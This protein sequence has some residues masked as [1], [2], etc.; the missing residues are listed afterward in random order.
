MTAGR[1]HKFIAAISACFVIA[2]VAE[3]PAHADTWILKDGKN[4]QDIG[5][6]P[7]GKYIIEISQFK[8]LIAQGKSS[9]AKKKL[10]EI[11]T[12]FPE[13]A[14][15]DL[16]AYM[17]AESFYARSDWARA[18]KEYEKFLNNYP[19]S[20]LYQA[21]LERRYDIATGFIHGQ[22][23]KVFKI[24]RFPAYSQG[25][26]MI[27][28]VSDRAGDS[29]ISQRALETLATR[30]TE[31]EK[32]LDAYETWA[33]MASKWPTGETGQQTQFGMAYSLHSAYKGPRYDAAVLASAKSYY[34]NII[35]RYPN[36]AQEAQIEDKIQLVDQQM[37][38]KQY[39]IALFYERTD[40]PEAAK[41]YFKRVIDEY[42]GTTA[43][44]LAQ[45]KMAFITGQKE[46]P[47]IDKGIRRKMF[48]AGVKAIDKWGGMINKPF[49]KILKD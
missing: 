3:A 15:P 39:N 2:I 47:V 46:A 4:W 19:D 8:D 23:R 44:R 25:V 18:A 49:K 10:N 17:Q 27:R 38:Y 48:D 36:E 7:K 13:L 31:K 9:A 14:G 45:E 33:E 43:A 5:Q 21:A 22:K 41:I 37:A 29:P 28:E 42:P 30:Q 26:D 32:Y 40:R 11:K 24:F 12:N 20:E 35:A 6:T 1:I 16:D 34:Q